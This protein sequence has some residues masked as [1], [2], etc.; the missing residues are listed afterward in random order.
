MTQQLD[1]KRPRTR[2][3]NNFTGTPDAWHSDKFLLKRSTTSGECGVYTRDTEEKA[4]LFC[5]KAWFHYL[6]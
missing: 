1:L 4:H 6:D 3:I 5:Q 2:T